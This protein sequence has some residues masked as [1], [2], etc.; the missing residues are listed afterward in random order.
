MDLNVLRKRVAESYEITMDSYLCSEE[1]KQSVL[2]AN[3]L[4]TSFRQQLTPDQQEAL[5][6]VLSIFNDIAE[7]ESIEALFRGRL[8]GLGIINE[9][10]KGDFYEQHN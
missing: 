4:Y 8:E 2:K 9:L 3:Q 1:Y 5:D 6:K 10:N 7:E